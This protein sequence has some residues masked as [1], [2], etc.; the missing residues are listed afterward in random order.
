MEMFIK[1]NVFSVQQVLFLSMAFAQEDVVQIKFI[2]IE[3]VFAQK[4]LLEEEKF[5]LI[6][7]IMVIMAINAIEIQFWEIIDV[8]VVQQDHTQILHKITAYVHPAKVIQ[9][10][11]IH[12]EMIVDSLILGMEIDADAHQIQLK[13]INNVFNV[14]LDQTQIQTRAPVYVKLVLPLIGFLINALQIALL[15]HHG[16]AKDVHV[17]QILSQLRMGNVSNVQVD[18]IQIQLKLLVYVRDQIKDTIPT[19]ED[20]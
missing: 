11:L 14:R 8:S 12:V 18:L 4:V 17:H 10:N 15:D 7:T 1:A 16:M 3:F 20:V 5:V 13:T 9:P 19:L 6:K 2:Q